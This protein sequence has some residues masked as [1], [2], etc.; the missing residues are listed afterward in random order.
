MAS[1]PNTRAGLI[2]YLRNLPSGQ[3]V[4]GQHNREP[5][6]TY[7]A[8]SWD[9]NNSADPKYYRPW[10]DKVNAITGLYPGLWGSDFLYNDPFAQDGWR[11]AMTQQAVDQWHAGSLVALTWHMTPPN[12]G[13]SSSADGVSTSWSGSDTS[14]KIDD[15]GYWRQDSTWQE[16]LDWQSNNGQGSSLYQN[17]LGR[18]NEAVPYFQTL[19]DAGVVVLFRPFHE[20]NTGWSWWG[21]GG[22]AQPYQRNYRQKLYQYTHNFFANTH[23]FDNIVW[24]W[25]VQNDGSTGVINDLYPGDDVVDV[26][27]HDVWDTNQPQDNWYEVLATLAAPGGKPLGLAEVGRLPDPN[28]ALRGQPGWKYFMCWAEFVD[29]DISEASQIFG[30]DITNYSGDQSNPNQYTKDVYYNGNVVHQGA[31]PNLS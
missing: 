10:T 23:G 27:S 15:S 19:K 30:Q 8:G 20:V 21:A 4:S 14:V 2:S 1:L 11:R 29:D 25:N 3:I 31:F 9:W 22:G 6:A 7:P 28:G 17:F 13:V 16:L 24:V 12:A 5:S 26:I 18:L